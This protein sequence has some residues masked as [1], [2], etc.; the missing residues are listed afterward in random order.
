[1]LGGGEVRLLEITNAY[2]VLA[3][4]GTYIPVSSIRR[5]VDARGSVLQ[6]YELPTVEEVFDPRIAYQ[7]TSILSDSKT[8]S[9]E[10]GP[11]TPLDLSR[12]AAAKTGTTDDNR[13][14]WTIGFTPQLVTGV[15]VGNSDGSP[16][17]NLTGM[18][19]ATPIWNAFMEAALADTRGAGICQTARHG[20][21]R[22]VHANGNAADALLR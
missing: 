8:R 4:G 16:T 12:P 19:G 20:G 2:S 21:S 10:F 15:W 18:R 13:D 17:Q 14:G 7:I 6:R 11:Y 1:M 9:A 22:G 5:V 3:R